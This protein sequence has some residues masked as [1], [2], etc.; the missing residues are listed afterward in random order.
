LLCLHM[1]WHTTSQTVIV[2][3]V[4]RGRALNSGMP[5]HRVHQGGHATS[6]HSFAENNQP[7]LPPV[8]TPALLARPRASG[9]NRLT[10]P[11]AVI[12]GGNWSTCPKTGLLLH[13]LLPRAYRAASAPL[14]MIP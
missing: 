2:S 6:G 8:F 11:A 14:I 12:G 13:G 7:L 1:P 4:R 10:R 5:S 9:E 3:V